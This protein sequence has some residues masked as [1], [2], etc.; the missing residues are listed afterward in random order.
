NCR[1]TW[2]IIWSCLVTVFSCTWVA[3]HPNIPAP[4]ETAFE[5]NL[6]RAGIMLM[7]VI[8]PELVILWA[9]RQWLVAR[10][11]ATRHRT[12]GWT[13]THGFFSTMGG[14]MLF[15]GRKPLQALSTEN[16]EDLA[17]ESRVRFPYITKREIEDRSK[18]DML[19][20]GFVIMQT[21]W[22][23]IQCVARGIEG[24][25]ITELE[26]VTLAFAILN[27]GTYFLWWDKPLNVLC[28]IP[29]QL[30]YRNIVTIAPV[31]KEED[32]DSPGLLKRAMSSASE[33]MRELRQVELQNIFFRVFTLPM[34][35]F[36]QLGFVDHEVES[37]AK[38]VP[39]F[40]TGALT[41]TEYS[42]A[43]FTD[44]A[45]AMI[46][47][48][49]H[50][51]AWSSH[52]PSPEKEI[53]GRICSLAITFLP[54]VLFFTSALL[55]GF[56]VQGI[57]VSPTIYTSVIVSLSLIYILARVM[58]IVEAFILLRTLPPEVFQTVNWTTFIPHI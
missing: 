16:L 45:V 2:S 49:I 48:S 18:G 47:G 15:D 3:I 21:G 17:L 36:F 28:P 54:A 38:R 29:V 24:L 5:I 37:G 55:S 57:S 10:K 58:L 12:K 8:A 50:C 1:T 46:F 4:Y 20:K 13:Q 27:L 26:L 51:I 44:T 31:G 52:F 53:L 19:S 30:G 25:P 35:P 22:F 39:T 33:S 41:P 23:T 42:I 32:E 7:A 40:Y 14:F 56:L 6:R 43:M 34:V 9:M 11:L